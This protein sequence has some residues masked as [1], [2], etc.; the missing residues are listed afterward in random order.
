MTVGSTREKRVER[1]LFESLSRFLLH[2]LATPLPCYV[3]ITAV[4]VTPVTEVPSS[5]N[6]VPDGEDNPST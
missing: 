3:S 6:S 5:R 1:E 2:D 4:S